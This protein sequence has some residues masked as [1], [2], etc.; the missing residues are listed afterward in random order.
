MII[1][2]KSLK[3]STHVKIL[4]LSIIKFR[5]AHMVHRTAK[6]LKKVSIKTRVNGK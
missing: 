6:V 5:T 3:L 1:D 4:E 2:P